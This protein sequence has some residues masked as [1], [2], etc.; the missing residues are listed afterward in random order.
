MQD[1]SQHIVQN[2]SDIDDLLNQG[3][4]NRTTASTNMNDTSS[5]SHAIFTIRFVQAKMVDNIPSET[6]SKMNLVDLA[7]S[8]RADST[9]ATGIRLKEGG[10]INKSLLTFIN[11]ISTLADLAGS[12]S[13]QQQRKPY[14]PYRDSV[15]TWLLKDS[16]GGNSKTVIL[17]AISPADINFVETLSTLRYANRAKNIINKPTIN[18]DPNVKLIR[19]LKAEIVRLKQL[20]E[21]N[22]SFSPASTP[23][24]KPATHLESQLDDDKNRDLIEQI[25][26]NQTKID[27]LTNQWKQKWQKYRSIFDENENLTLEKKQK[28]GV[29]LYASSQP[30]LVVIDEPIPNS[31]GL[32]I[33]PLRNG[34]TLIGTAADQNEILIYA[35]N[36]N[37]SCYLH[38][39]ENKVYLNPLTG[40][41]QVNNKVIMNELSDVH[42][43]ELSIELRHGDLILLGERNL[44]RFNSPNEIVDD[45]SILEDEPK[46]TDNLTLSYLMRKLIEDKEKRDE[47]SDLKEKLVKNEAMFNENRKQIQQMQEQIELNNGEMKKLKE[48]SLKEVANAGYLEGGSSSNSEA[49]VEARWLDVAKSEHGSNDDE[50]EKAVVIEARSR[51]ND[52]IMQT[53]V[54]KFEVN[55][56]QIKFSIFSKIFKS[57]SLK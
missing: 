2:Y 16:L 26:Q 10:N 39:T 46:D 19:E 41:C 30:Y 38:R 55:I 12:S 32:S 17:A 53:L 21:S 29:S 15:L 4:L 56:D 45:N 8:E 52:E 43:E 36:K 9:G 13:D 18:E 49:A 20:F 57:S 11:V 22:P 7:G 28:S 1:L 51:H 23:N 35:Q 5:R 50:F 24:P 33:Y 54:E 14:I 31:N 6:I 40:Y 34:K 37:L 3:N 27:E 48:A 25:N 47:I 42:L 44:F